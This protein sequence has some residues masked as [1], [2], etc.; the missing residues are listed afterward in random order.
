[1]KENAILKINQIGKVSSI[2]TTIAKI[3]IGVGFVLCLITAIVFTAIPEEFLTM[4]MSGNAVIDVNL[5]TLG[6]A[7]D[8]S[9]MEEFLYKQEESGAEVSFDINSSN[10]NLKDMTATEKS[11]Q[12]EAVSEDITMNLHNL[13]WVMLMGALSLGMTMVTLFFIGALCKAFRNCNSPFEENVTKKMQ[14]LA[15][16][17]VPWAFLTSITDALAQSYFTGKFQLAMSI[18]LH[19]VLIIL[20]IFVLVYIFKYGAVLQRESDETL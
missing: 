20:L 3:L 11:L 9:D 17:L 14:N 8:E 2:F 1:M 18:D 10:Y 16:S 6:I 12:L 4:R 5:D 7:F 19:M 15:I 13:V